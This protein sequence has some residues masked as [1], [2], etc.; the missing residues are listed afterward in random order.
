MLKSISIAVNIIL[1]VWLLVVC[2][3]SISDKR[4]YENELQ[5]LAA[6]RNY[7]L[8]KLDSNNEGAGNNYLRS[9]KLVQ[10]IIQIYTNPKGKSDTIY[11]YKLK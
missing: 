4:F 8:N 3:V 2:Q 11:V 5:N 1:F 7:I 6:E 10:P 9:T